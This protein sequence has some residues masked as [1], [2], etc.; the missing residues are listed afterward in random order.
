M[1]LLVQRVNKASVHCDQRLFSEIN[2]GFLVL[3][4]FAKTD[5]VSLF[6]KV[7]HR[8]LNVALFDD[9]Q[10]KMG[11]SLLDV[12]GE[13]LLVS[14]FTLYGKLEKGRK[15]N[16]DEAMPYAAAE[17]LYNQFLAYLKENYIADKV[18]S[19]VF[20]GEMLVD[21]QN[22]GPVTLMIES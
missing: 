7:V 13:L 21:L 5:N 9:E 12:Q 20:G 1:R 10:G 11:K 3:V 18:K 17:L 14:Q 8:L 16:W 2:A 15:V 19:G 4:G 22:D 6:P